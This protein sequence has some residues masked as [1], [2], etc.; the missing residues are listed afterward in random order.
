MAG[1]L[2]ALG[3]ARANR[4][5][6]EAAVEG[7]GKL[8]AAQSAVEQAL[9]SVPDGA[10]PE[11]RD[12]ARGPDYRSRMLEAQSMIESLPAR[13]GLLWGLPGLGAADSR[14]VADL[15]T[16]AREERERI[17][18]AVALFH[19]SGGWQQAWRR[20]TAPLRD[21]LRSVT[22]LDADLRPS[23]PHE[24]GGHLLEESER[25]GRDLEGLDAELL[26]GSLSYASATARLD[27]L[28]EQLQRAAHAAEGSRVRTEGTGAR[29]NILD[30][31]R[32]AEGFADAFPGAV[33]PAPRWAE[34]S[35][36][37]TGISFDLI[38]RIEA[39]NAALERAVRE[40][41]RR[42]PT[43]GDGDDS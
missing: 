15:V 9:A 16:R 31:T 36:D 24:A 14:L 41:R 1:V 23:L 22:G 38:A 11:S 8:R 28:T 17:T 32:G 26:A 4:L 3:I 29:S 35:Q 5:R 27:A 43:W 7:Y 42:T 25:I 20:T 10:A 33:R 37:D 12:L 30:E 40:D 34:P 19:R 39:C 21:A 2:Y 18:D 6:V 13:R